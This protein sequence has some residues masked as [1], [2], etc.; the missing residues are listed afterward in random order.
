MMGLCDRGGRLYNDGGTALG[1][2]DELSGRPWLDS[3]LKA[4]GRS[5]TGE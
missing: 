4:E 1:G 2:A 3:S 5:N